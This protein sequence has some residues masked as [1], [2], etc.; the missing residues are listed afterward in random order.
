VEGRVGSDEPSS[1]TGRPVRYGTVL[2]L[3]L[4]SIATPFVVT[5]DTAGATVVALLQALTVAAALLASRVSPRTVRI[6]VVG[7]VV[8]VVVVV[9]AG[10]LEAARGLEAPL[11]TDAARVIAIVLALYV[12]VL[13]VRDVVLRHPTI[14]LQT[15]WA[16]LCLYLL[17]GL[18]F[19]ALH[20]MIERAAPGSY[21]RE[22]DQVTAVYFSYVTMT[23]VG[24][25]DITP[26]RGPAQAV[27][28]LH[29]VIGQLYLVS[30]VAAVVGNLGRQREPRR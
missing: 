26:V 15:V 21:S 20:L 2:L 18:A 11:Q 7:L 4:A 27:T 5:G 6:T 9:G 30:I 28:L 22:L 19:S 16:A 24:F 1:V 12:P 29:A 25:G 14:S 10:V 8:A 17:L 3:I 13:I 23:T